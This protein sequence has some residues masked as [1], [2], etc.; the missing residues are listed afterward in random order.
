M[1]IR[2]GEAN[3]RPLSEK[4]GNKKQIFGDKH[5]E[6]FTIKGELLRHE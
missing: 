6:S 4:R 1:N 3:S 2:K 5:I